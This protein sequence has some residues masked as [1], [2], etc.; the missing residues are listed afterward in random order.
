M[1]DENNE[2]QE[3]ARER[4]DILHGTAGA[5]RGRIRALT[6][7]LND[8]VSARKDAALALADAERWPR[9]EK[10]A[11]ILGEAQQAHTRA[12]STAN[13]TSRALERAR[14]EGRRPIGRAVAAERLLVRLK[15]IEEKGWVVC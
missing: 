7:Q 6:G 12:V 9:T 14:L 1:H 15:L 3:R 10:S 8:A 11:A 4:F 13:R 5:E 2:W